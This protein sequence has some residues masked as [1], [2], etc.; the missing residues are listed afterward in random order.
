MQGRKKEDNSADI[1]IHWVWAREQGSIVNLTYWEREEKK[2][3][4]KHQQKGGS[5]SYGIDP[6]IQTT[7]LNLFSSSEQHFG[8]RY[9]VTL[10]Q[11][12][13]TVL[14]QRNLLILQAAHLYCCVACT[15]SFGPKR[16]E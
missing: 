14:P 2:Q 16:A 6:R 4:K 13:E 9:Q 12:K 7:V 11:K 3:P 5:I 15:S 10:I 8:T 1:G